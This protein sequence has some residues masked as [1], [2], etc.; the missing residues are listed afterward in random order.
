MQITKSRKERPVDGFDPTTVPVFPVL[1]VEVADG[2][3]LV[4]GRVETI[5]SGVSA[6]DAAVE[7][8]AEAVRRRGL[9]YC[10]VSAIVGGVAYP[11][12]VGADGSRHDLST[13]TRARRSPNGTTP[14]AWV[15]PVAVMVFALVA[16]GVV[17]A[18]VHQFRGQGRPAPVAA[19]PSPSPTELPVLPPDGWST[20]ASWA[21]PLASLDR[22]AVLVYDGAVLAVTDDDALTSHDALTGVIL[23][24]GNIQGALKAGPVVTTIDGAVVIA[25]ATSRHLYWWPA[26]RNLA[27]AQRVELEPSAQVSFAGTGPLITLPGQHAATIV[28]GVL[29]DRTVPAGA[30]AIRAD[31]PAVTA[32]DT[33]GH[34]WR[35]P[36][37]QPHVP[38]P[39]AT[40]R[41]PKRGQLPT[42]L[43]SAG[44]YLMLSWRSESGA[45][46]GTLTMV[47]LSGK[48]V[49]RRDVPA[50][51]G[52][53]AWT[54]GTTAAVAAGHTFLLQTP[55]VVPIADPT[56][57][58]IR[59]VGG[60]IYGTTHGGDS[61][62]LT[63]GTGKVQVQRSVEATAP[64]AMSADRAFVAAN[65]PDGPVLYALQRN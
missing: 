26:V 54:A 36:D 60:T 21:V 39:V 34:L 30:V 14:R 45:A 37:T 49:A 50:L 24:T 5:P 18:T 9:D 47:N 40:L 33:A 46:T 64:L 38:A 15:L 17:V 57:R 65:T 22:A 8:A 16:A 12:V 35:L 62:I 59:V 52:G 55:R 19:A 32:V 41:P 28:A 6:T 13:P 11:L 20:H 4:D 23:S 7:A 31:G 58:S 51:K 61:A 42:L 44:A 56:W 25:V 63:A 10:R 29:S 2:E 27:D 43:G 53:D 48:T 1:T 3:L